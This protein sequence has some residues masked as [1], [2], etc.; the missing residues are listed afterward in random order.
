LLEQ[1]PKESYTHKAKV[2]TTASAVP[3]PALSTGGSA[4]LR[5]ALPNW[6]VVAKPEWQAMIDCRRLDVLEKSAAAECPHPETSVPSQLGTLQGH[7]TFNKALNLKVNNLKG[8]V[9]GFQIIDIFI[10]LHNFVT[11]R[12]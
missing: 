2:P 8:L 10:R 5:T 3:E 1:K 4:Q 6:K 12:G 11:S 7:N 9:L